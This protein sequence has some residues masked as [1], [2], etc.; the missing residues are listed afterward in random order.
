MGGGKIRLYLDLKSFSRTQNLQT[1]ACFLLA[2]FDDG[3]QGI[4]TALGTVVE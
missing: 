3:I 1:V 4:I 2:G